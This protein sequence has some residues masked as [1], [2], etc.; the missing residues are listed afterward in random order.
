MAGLSGYLRE[1]EI[2]EPEVPHSAGGASN[3]KIGVEK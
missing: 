1:A 3:A 2:K